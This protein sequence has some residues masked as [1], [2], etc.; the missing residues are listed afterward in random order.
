LYL[1]INNAFKL[2][3][4]YGTVR[5]LLRPWFLPQEEKKNAP[6]IAPKWNDGNGGELG[7]WMETQ[8][9]SSSVQYNDSL[10]S[11]EDYS[12]TATQPKRT[13]P[14]DKTQPTDHD[15]AVS[16]NN[17]SSQQ[18]DHYTRQGNTNDDNTLME[19]DIIAKGSEI[20]ESIYQGNDTS[21]VVDTSA[22]P[23]LPISLLCSFIL[24]KQRYLE[25]KD[26]QIQRLLE[27]VCSEIKEDCH[28]FNLIQIVQ[29]VINELVAYYQ[30]SMAFKVLD[31]ILSRVFGIVR[32]KRE[33]EY[34]ENNWSYYRF[35]FHNNTLS[36]K[37]Q[38]CSEDCL[39][40]FQPQVEKMD[41]PQLL[42]YCFQAILESCRTLVPLFLQVL[43]ETRLPNSI[44]DRIIGQ[45]FKSMKYMELQE[46]QGIFYKLLHFANGNRSTCELFF[47]NFIEFVSQ[48]EQQCEMLDYYDSI[49]ASQD[50]GI[51]LHSY[52]P[53]TLLSFESR[54]SLL[55]P[56]NRNPPLEETL[57]SYFGRISKY[58]T[59]LVFR[60]FW[61]LLII[62][63][64][65]KKFFKQSF[66]FSPRKQKTRHNFT[67]HPGTFH[68]LLG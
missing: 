19:Q 23:L 25:Q 68:R 22:H 27:L 26:M 18:E 38:I 58:E 3:R 13:T 63:L 67:V 53:C 5:D 44:G 46:I 9:S 49:H 28:P 35:Q 17:S 37:E 15:T 21:F 11:E 40:S 36:I 10:S 24:E 51:R 50:F 4:E 31:I 65:V 59:I 34:R 62:V 61:S 2:A 41:G 12:K 7:W 32:K 66:L 64:F 47:T 14:Q 42:F 45:V 33:V 8:T 52:D 56:S 57:S 60:F 6:E 48:L 20:L 39:V 1:S 29:V 16:S 54:C 43:K 30:H 55:I